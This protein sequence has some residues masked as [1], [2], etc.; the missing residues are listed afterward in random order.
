MDQQVLGWI[1]APFF[2]L[3]P[4]AEGTGLGLSAIHGI[5]N[6]L[7]GAPGLGPKR[8]NLE[9]PFGP[10]L[11]MSNLFQGRTCLTASAGAIRGASTA[12]FPSKPA[13]RMTE[14]LVLTWLIGFFYCKNSEIFLLYS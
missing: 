12:T 8:L 6:S 14:T 11:K 10:P 2:T 5:I 13:A 9:S 1:F 7:G 3:K 4:V